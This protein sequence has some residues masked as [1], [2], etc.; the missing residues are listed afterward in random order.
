M[1]SINL[2]D[3][4][5]NTEEEVRLDEFREVTSDY[6][7]SL[8]EAPSDLEF[9]WDDQVE[10]E[11]Q[12][13]LKKINTNEN[14]LRLGQYKKRKV[15][16]NS[17][18]ELKKIYKIFGKSNSNRIKSKAIKPKLGNVNVEKSRITGDFKIGNY[19]SPDKLTNENNQ[20]NTKISQATKK[21]I[22]KPPITK[23]TS[24]GVDLE[25]SQLL[26]ASLPIMKK[27][28]PVD[29]TSDVSEVTIN[30]LPKRSNSANLNKEMPND[31]K[32]SQ[33]NPFTQTLVDEEA[34]F[35]PYGSI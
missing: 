9:E 31:N 4:S 14:Q 30:C 35:R 19:D 34:K 32:I 22:P 6:S 5:I 26:G 2:N 28:T 17:S 25:S 20:D 23:T 29:D 24:V 1:I 11:F 12:E 18:F 16:R 21:S 27:K 10:K 7:A 13:Y 33:E 8:Q 15:K 3:V